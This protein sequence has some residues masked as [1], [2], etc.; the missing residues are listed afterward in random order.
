VSVSSIGSNNLSAVSAQ[1]Y[2]QSANSLGNTLNST[3]ASQVSPLSGITSS[4]SDGDTFQLSGVVPPPPP[5][6]DAA[7]SNSTSSDS[8]GSLNSDIQ[9]FLSKVA[10]GTVSSSD[11]DSMQSE[12][13]QYLSNSSTAS[14][15]SSSDSLTSGTATDYAQAMMMPPPPP[16][17]DSSSSE[18]SSDVESFLNKV[19]D[20]SVS[21]SDIST[22]ESE[23]QQYL[24]SS[25]STSDTSSNDSLASGTATD[26][27]QAMMPPPPPPAN[28]TGSS[29]TSSDLNSDIE[30]FLSKV[31][32]GSISTSDI[33]IMQSELQQLK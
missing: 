6:P 25:S 19:A 7:G 33:Q 26:F 31:A 27:S 8:S 18:L 22:M 11:I 13:Q 5:P 9:S 24:S 1:Y 17:T 21:S 20:G 16:P 30:S 3:L 28:T 23:L 32:D 10:E 15:T 4:N 29:S 14:A 2:T 12:L